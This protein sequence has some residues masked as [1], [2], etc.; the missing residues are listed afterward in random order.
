DIIKAAIYLDMSSLYE[1]M[2]T[3]FFTQHKYLH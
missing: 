3:N 2:C 1:F